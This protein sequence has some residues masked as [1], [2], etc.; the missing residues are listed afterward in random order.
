[1]WRVNGEV[2]DGATEATLDH[3]H[4]L[5]ADEVN[6]EVLVS[7]GEFSQTATADTVIQDSAPSFTVIGMPE[8]AQYGE[9]TTFQVLIEDVDDD[10][11]TWEFVSR[12]NGMTRDESG[13]V[14]WTPTG[15]MFGTSIDTSWEIAAY[16]AEQEYSVQRTIKVIDNDRPMV[17]SRGGVSLQAS[18]LMTAKADLDGKGKYELVTAGPYRRLFTLAANGDK[19]ELNWD[20]P[21]A[22]AGP[23]ERYT[24]VA[25]ADMNGD[26]RD[27]ILVGVEAH[28]L[29]ARDTTH[30]YIFDDNRRPQRVG[31]VPGNDVQVIRVADVNDDGELEI[32]LMVGIYNDRTSPDEVM[33]QKHLVI[34]RA[35]DLSLEWQSPVLELGSNIAVGNV[36][37]D[38]YQEIATDRGYVF[39]FNGTEYEIKWHYEP[40]F[41][42]LADSFADYVSLEIVDVD[43]DGD[44]EIV[45][46]HLRFY[47]AITKSVINSSSVKA[48][49][50]TAFDLDG[51]EVPEFL[52]K[53]Q[54]YKFDANGT[55]NFVAQWDTP[56]SGMSNG[57]LFAANMDDDPAIEYLI[58]QRGL[59]SIYTSSPGDRAATL[60]WVSDYPASVYTEL[61]APHFLD[62]NGQGEK[63]LLVGKDQSLDTITMATIDPISGATSW[64]YDIQQEFGYHRYAGVPLD[65]GNDGSMQMFHINNSTPAVFDF[66]SGTISWRGE[67]TGSSVVTA[68]Q[69]QLASSSA[70]TALFTTEDG[71]LRAYDTATLLP[72][73]QLANAGGTH[74]VVADIDSDGQQDVLSAS[75]QA[76]NLIS[77]EAS[78]PSIARTLTLEDLVPEV[79]DENYSSNLQY[80]EIAS[81]SVGKPSPAS[82]EKIALV[83][84]TRAYSGSWLIVLNADFSV[85]SLTA[86]ADRRIHS[87]LFQNYGDVNR[88]L[89]L[90]VQLDAPRNPPWPHYYYDH[91]FMEVSPENGK[92][93]SMSPGFATD[94]IPGSMK[95]VDTNN[96][97]IQ[98]L[99]WST[100]YASVNATR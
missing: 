64:L 39:G 22:F 42:E 44:K 59:N 63:I 20:Y 83:V 67:D 86:Y 53:D 84:S 48:R 25:A 7:D 33:S 38:P 57:L 24:S 46:P 60:K 62:A 90:N 95:Y 37:T 81:I 61:Y 6:V 13:T 78:G 91:Y 56:L 51:D 4:F 100:A 41:R 17:L 92:A 31:N 87:A 93:V 28:Y 73:W 69:G 23:T 45:G 55:G 99:I 14:S 65:L 15:P 94:A 54:L 30:I 5:K 58:P 36:D 21:Y 19:F 71:T 8:T 16:Q 97:G 80:L 70:I 34:L 27:Q 82:A 3:Q 98:E 11:F 89:L 50:F 49:D 47:D 52:T 29:F 12:P 40:G 26:G 75:T 9:A 68:A 79:N 66:G 85:Y 72:S 32:V 96:D 74:L 35:S 18:R 76:L 2:I 43:G 10:A 77:V 1:M 88:N